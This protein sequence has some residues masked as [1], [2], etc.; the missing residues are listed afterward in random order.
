MAALFDYLGYKNNIPL[1]KFTITLPRINPL[2]T[3]YERF[4]IHTVKRKQIEGHWVEHEGLHKWMP[5]I[6]FQYVNLWSIEMK[7]KDSSSKGKVIGKPRLR[8]IEWIK[9]FVHSAARGF[10]GFKDDDVFSCHRILIDPEMEELLPYLST[11]TRNSL[12]NS[13]GELKQYKSAL[14]YLY[15]Y[16]TSNLGKPLFYNTALNVVEIGARNYGKTMFS[17]NMCGHNFL[18]D[19]VMDF[20]EWVNNKSLPKEEQEIYTT[21]TLIGASDSKYINNLNKHLK[22]GLEYLPGKQ[23][24]GGKVYPPPLAKQYSGS[25]V[26]GKD[27]I[28]KYEEKVGTRWEVKGSGSG[29]L[30]RT[31]KDNEFAANGSRYGFGLV[32]EVGFMGNLIETLGQLHECTTVDGEKYG[33]IWMTGTGGDMEGGATIAVKKVFYRPMDYDCLEFD[34]IFE[35]TGRKQGFFV[36]AWMTLDEFR[37]EFG[38]INRVLAERKLKKE[39]DIKIKG[40]KKSYNDLLQMKPLIPSEAF[41]VS[42]GNIF[43]RPE[44]IEHIKFLETSQDGYIKGRYGTMTL[45]GTHEASFKEDFSN[46]YR[47]CSY[48]LEEKDDKEGCVVIWEEPIESPPFGYYIAS[49]DPYAQDKASNSVSLGSMFVMKRTMVGGSSYDEIVAEYTGRPETQDEF[50]ENC[51][52]LILYYNAICLYEN[53]YNQFKTHMQNKNTLHLLAKEP[54]ALK[55]NKADAIA[56]VYGW[57]TNSNKEE[58]ELYLRDWLFSDAGDGKLNLHHIYSVPLLKELEG[59]NDVGNFDRV[60]SA[61]LLV[62][63]KIQMHKIIARDRDNQKKKWIFTHRMNGVI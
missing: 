11:K 61:G 25:W 29:F 56:N 63:Q 57:N 2:S 33:T 12:Y 38:N 15:E 53:N 26:A 40:S 51:R 42:G 22:N 54:T 43:H 37:D 36:P 9:G 5:G 32:D 3:N 23:E 62:I 17:G 47:P 49:L 16:Q 6:L 27:V 45:T 21:Q 34:D 52:K 30:N 31:F 50:H 58:L 60:I 46:R 18:T 20:D 44:L 41:L 59:Y 39:R 8:D 13:K 10:S 7:K 55:K 4:W 35:G 1:D 14:E 28:A 19:G 48:P 24:I